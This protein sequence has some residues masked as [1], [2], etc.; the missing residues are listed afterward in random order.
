MVKIWFETPTQATW[1]AF[2]CD[3][4]IITVIMYI[5]ILLSWKLSNDFFW[6]YFQIMKI[7]HW[8][9]TS[10]KKIPVWIIVDSAKITM[11]FRKRWV[12]LLSVTNK[13]V[14]SRTAAACNVGAA[15]VV[16]FYH[17]AQC[18]GLSSY[19]ADSTASTICSVLF[20]VV[21]RS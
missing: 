7:W 3:K 11:G 18:S 9:S 19:R 6:N 16:H 5:L 17:N 20:I 14:G 4:K 21:V 13:S 10:G 2:W 15:F 1:A 12:K 8:T